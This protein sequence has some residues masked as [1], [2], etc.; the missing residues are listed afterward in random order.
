[1]ASSCVCL[2]FAL[3]ISAIAQS[4]EPAGA[5]LRDWE[6]QAW[7]A[8]FDRSGGIFGRTSDHGILQRF[9]AA[10]DE[11]YHLDVITSR[12][13][14]S[15]TADWYRRDNGARIWVGSINHLRLIVHGEFK[16]S[17]RLADNWAADVRF[18]KEETLLAD[19]SLARVGLRHRLLDGR[20]EAF[21]TGTVVADKPESDIELGF[22]WFTGPGSITVAV[23]ALDVFSDLIYENLEVSPSIADTAFDYTDNP[24]TARF[25]LDLPLG[26]N[27]R[28]EGHALALTP[29]TVE[30]GSQTRPGDGFLQQ[31]RYAYAGGLLEWSPSR[32]TAIGT[33]TTWVRSRLDRAPLAAGPPED[34]FDLTEV[35]W[36]IGGYAIHHITDRLEAEAWLSR[37]GRSEDRLRPDTTVAANID[38]EDQIWL[39]SAGTVYRFPSGFQAQL[40]FDIADQTPLSDD[41]LPSVFDA[42]H[43]RLRFELGWRFG[44]RALIVLGSNLDLDGDDRSPNF[45]GGHGRVRLSW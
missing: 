19:R 30:I 13:S 27:L 37:V 5:T 39:A 33:F 29:T 2:L 28:I 45:D 18:N 34:A 12:F 25:S 42:T 8:I 7:L 3:P 9:N 6:E 1:L 20:A 23:A 10:M 4:T 43:T 24:Y 11:E 35:T 17:V 31:E 14:L 16:A 44:S 15:E 38:F 41:R 26:R 21:L 22:V 40:E 36:R 32:N